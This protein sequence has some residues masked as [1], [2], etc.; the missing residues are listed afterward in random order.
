MGPLSQAERERQGITEW[1]KAR[2]N[3]TDELLSGDLEWLQ[4]WREKVL[5]LS[6]VLFISLL[7]LL[8][9]FVLLLLLL[10]LSSL[11]LLSLLSLSLLS[12]LSLLLLGPPSAGRVP[13][14]GRAGGA[15]RLRAPV[16]DNHDHDMI[17]AMAYSML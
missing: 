5:L 14:E 13:A 4:G 16:G 6:L 2:Y 8:L 11:L 3:L 1:S 12:L 9:L 17:Y 10:L 7:L 15:A